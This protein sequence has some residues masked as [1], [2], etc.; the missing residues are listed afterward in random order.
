MWCVIN[1]L[2]YW[3]LFIYFIDDCILQELQEEQINISGGRCNFKLRDLLTVP[4]Q[5]VLK[6][7]LLLKVCHMCCCTCRHV[8]E[9]NFSIFEVCIISL[10]G[11]KHLTA[12][13]T[14]CIQHENNNDTLVMYICTYICMYM[15]I[16]PLYVV[17]HCDIGTWITRIKV[18]VK[19]IIHHKRQINGVLCMMCR[20]L[21][22]HKK[23]DVR[24]SCLQFFGVRQFCW[25]YC[26]H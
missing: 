22:R 16:W 4:M 25:T 8:S 18:C 7:H 15:C 3:L 19:N 26:S 1:W 9:T 11:I 20:V 6:Y 21:D 2:I 12:I 17:Y 13:Y 24:T 10:T 14:K 23:A 5:R